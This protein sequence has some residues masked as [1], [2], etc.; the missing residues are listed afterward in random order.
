MTAGDCYKVAAELA[1]ELGGTLCHGEPLLRNPATGERGPRYG[2]AWV[3]LDDLVLDFAN[4]RNLRI[5]RPQYYML[6]SIAERDVKRY[7]PA[8]TWA[9]IRHHLHWGPWE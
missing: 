8:E 4:G 2:H 5:A 3:E 6:G 1:M 9:T 7:T